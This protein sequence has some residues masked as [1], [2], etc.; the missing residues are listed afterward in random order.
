[1][2]RIINIILTIGVFAAGYFLYRTIQEPIVFN[3][4]FQQRDAQVIKKLKYIRD[5]QVAYKDV[6]DDFTASF[7]S[8]VT[9]IKEDSMSIIRIIGDPDELDAEGNPVPVIREIIKI[10]VQDS[11]MNPAYGL[12]TL[13]NIPGVEGEQFIMEKAILERGRIKVPVFHVVA[14]YPKM[15]KGLN[16]NYIDPTLVRKVGSLDEPSYNGN[17]EGK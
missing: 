2:I 3:R 9:F 14:E 17:W 16:K 7:D 8:L 11:L 10:P 12:A 13:G 4:E 5:L 6:H 1:M 15:L